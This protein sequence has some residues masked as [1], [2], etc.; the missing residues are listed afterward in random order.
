[1]Q[2]QMKVKQLQNKHTSRVG[3]HREVPPYNAIVPSPIG[4]LGI[5]TQANKLCGIH[6]LPDNC[7]TVLPQD[8]MT[9]R[10]FDELQLYFANPE[11]IF[12]LDLEIEGTVFQKN[13]WRALG[14][15]SRG[16]P[17]HYQQLAHQLNTGARAVGNACRANRI[18]LVIPCHR[19]IAKH[20]LGGFGG[21]T[22]GN[23]LNIKKWL[24]QHEQS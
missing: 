6:F 15:I 14:N 20:H 23:W 13:V 5:H 12:Q 19:V 1:M 2:A 7:K 4:Q 18:P 8:A 17:V 9:Q 24:L 3:T 11:H 10:V 22:N 16:M 21:H